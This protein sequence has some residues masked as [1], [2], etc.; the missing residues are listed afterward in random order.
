MNYLNSERVQLIEDCLREEGFRFKPDGSNKLQSDI[1]KD[2]FLSDLERVID[3]YIAE[4]TFREAHDQLQ[5]L[6]EL[7]AE[8]DPSRY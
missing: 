6:W 3:L 8:D 1:E 2:K 7:C 5:K 4:T